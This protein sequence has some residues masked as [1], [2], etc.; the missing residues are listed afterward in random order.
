MPWI[1]KSIFV[2]FIAVA[3]GA[4]AWPMPAAA[5]EISP[6]RLAAA[7]RV[8]LSAPTIRDWDVILPQLATQVKDRLIAQRPDLFREIAVAVDETAL[9]IAAERR[10]E[11]DNDIA[12]IWARAFTEDELIA[13]DAFFS[14]D[15]GVKYKEVASKTV[16][17]E[18]VQASRNWRNRLG[19][20]LLEK[21]TAALARMGN[22][23]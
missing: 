9:E 14:S 23:L 6:S 7:G 11:L 12:R 5:Q 8:A 2:V 20:E 19:D 15:V 18:I 13:I 10:A 16:G 21:S 3:V 22:Q 17:P 4:G 1:G